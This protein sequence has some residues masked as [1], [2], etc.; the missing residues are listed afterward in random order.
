ML[1]VGG[2]WYQDHKIVLKEVM[3]ETAGVRGGEET[4]KEGFLLFKYVKS[5]D[6]A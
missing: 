4:K 2:G 6:Q 1:A 3:N 5:R